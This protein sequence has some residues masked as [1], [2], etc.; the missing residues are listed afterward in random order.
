MT[1]LTCEQLLLTTCVGLLTMPVGGRGGEAFLRAYDRFEA[2]ERRRRRAVPTADDL[3]PRV[4]LMSE[5][6]PDFGPVPGDGRG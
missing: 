5:H 1:R 2:S 6:F 4:E 3:L